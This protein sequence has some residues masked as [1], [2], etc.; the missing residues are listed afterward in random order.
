[1]ILDVTQQ[2]CDCFRR[3][4]SDIQCFQILL[5]QNTVILDVISKKVI[6]DVIPHKKMILDVTQRKC[7]CF[8]RYS[9][10]IQCFQI[11]LYQS[12]VIW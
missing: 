11:I 7:D 10:D 9:S 4:S 3:Y 1:M 8:R 6:L 2:K 12:T 5:N